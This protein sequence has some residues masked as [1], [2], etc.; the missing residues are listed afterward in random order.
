[1]RQLRELW[2]R[3]RA[4]TS[5][6]DRLA[7][8]E[9]LV[10]PTLGRIEPLLATERLEQELAKP[11]LEN[12]KRLERFGFKALSQFDADGIL[13]EIFRRVG[14][15]HRSFVEFGTGD[16]T[17]N[18]T[19]YWLCQGWRGLWI[20][21]SEALH[22]A[23]QRNFDWAL[24]EGTLACARSF[25]TRDNINDVVRGRGFTGP[26]DLLSV[27][28]DG[29]DYHLW[30]ALTCV[31]PRVVVVEYNAYVPPRCAGSWPTTQ[32]IAGI[33]RARILARHSRR[34]KP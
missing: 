6:G 7:R 9:N 8:L 17:E 16:G 32:A 4:L 27:D 22:H 28:V 2:R 34:S 14:E 15:E 21:G 18:N 23:Q 24:R 3:L 25:L 13:R 12:P 31:E 19:V 29:N 26:I 5:I 30:E 10:G 33:T 11:E 20:D 1:M